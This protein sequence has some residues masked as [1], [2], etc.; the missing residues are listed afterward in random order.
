M[1]AVVSLVLGT[2]P[3]LAHPGIGIVV[4]KAGNVYFTDLKQVWKIAPD[5]TK[6]V[7]V[8]QVHTHELFLDDQNDLFGEHLWYESAQDKFWHYPWRLTAQR[9]LERLAPPEAGFDYKYSLVRDAAGNQYLMREKRLFRVRPD[10]RVE[11]VAGGA[12]A[13]KDGVG[14]AA[15][16]TDVV[17]MHAARD[18]TLYLTDL[19][20]LRRVSP[21]GEVRTLPARFAPR[22]R[23]AMWVQ[24][25]HALMGIAADD[26][27]NVFVANYGAGRVEKFGADGKMSVLHRSAYPYGPTGVAL[28]GDAVYVLEY[29]LD[30]VR[31]F[32]IASGAV[33]RLF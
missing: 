29:A 3:A 20:H 24:P 5:G 33:T 27:G 13:N 31:V 18:G 16:F 17:W 14:A 15:G 30:S 22:R 26:A 11:F 32:K 2:L 8:P 28:R 1:A 19:G 9:K 7:A 12:V 25:R 4:D 21:S 6:T 10:G 23:S